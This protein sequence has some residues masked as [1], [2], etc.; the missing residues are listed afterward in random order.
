MTDETRLRDATPEEDKL[1]RYLSR[2]AGQA[3]VH[4]WDQLP[5][6]LREDL[7]M[8]RMF[9]SALAHN[10]GQ[11]LASAPK[12]AIP[13]EDAGWLEFIETTCEMVRTQA[14]EART[15]LLLAQQAETL[16]PIAGSP[17]LGEHGLLDERAPHP[18]QIPESKLIM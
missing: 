1:I 6:E 9:C 16:G 2:V 7:S 13:V 14:R 17:T 18:L 11:L 5:P 3:V 8:T 10:L 15:R 12:D 4:A